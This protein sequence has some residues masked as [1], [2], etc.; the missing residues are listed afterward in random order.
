MNPACGVVQ[1]VKAGQVMAA[2]PLATIAM[3]YAYGLVLSLMGARRA[4]LASSI[5]SAPR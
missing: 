2:A 1:A 5:A 3:V 4:L